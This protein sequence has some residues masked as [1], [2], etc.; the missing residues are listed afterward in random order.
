MDLYFDFDY[1]EVIVTLYEQSRIHHRV[2][3]PMTSKHNIFFLP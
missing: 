2:A 1:N 3:E